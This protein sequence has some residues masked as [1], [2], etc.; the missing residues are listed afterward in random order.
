MIKLRP[1]SSIIQIQNSGISGPQ[2]AGSPNIRNFRSPQ[3]ENYEEKPTGTKFKPKSKCVTNTFVSA[4]VSDL[5]PNE[6][7]ATQFT[8]DKF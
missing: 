2:F 3:R 4:F 5:Y 1:E 7:S 6:V 8:P